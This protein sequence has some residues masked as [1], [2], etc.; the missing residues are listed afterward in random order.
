MS[1]ACPYACSDHD[2]VSLSLTAL[3]HENPVELSSGVSKSSYSACVKIGFILRT[4]KLSSWRRR[5]ASTTASAT[6]AF[7][8]TRPECSDPSKPTRLTVIIRSPLG[9]TGHPSCHDAPRSAAVTV[10]MNE[11]NGFGFRAGAAASGG[12]AGASSVL[13]GAAGGTVVDVVDVDVVDVDVDVVEVDVDVDVVE[14][15]E[16][17]GGDVACA[18]DALPDPQPAATSASSSSSGGA[19]TRSARRDLTSVLTSRMFTCRIGVRQAGSEPARP[20]EAM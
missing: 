9:S 2:G 12:G 11:L 1:I 4:G 16:V 17:A 8:T 6:S 13:V 18:V 15:L 5:N 19:R 14:V 7:T 20:Q 3:R 10:S